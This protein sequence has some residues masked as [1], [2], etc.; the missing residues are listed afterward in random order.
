MSYQS[1]GHQEIDLPFWGKLYTVLSLDSALDFHDAI[2][3]PIK[4]AEALKNVVRKAILNNR[5]SYRGGYQDIG[6]AEHA[7]RGICE[8]FGEASLGSFISWSKSVF[9][10]NSTRHTKW[11]GWR[12]VFVYL[13]W[14]LFRLDYIVS[15]SSER[16]GAAY[17]EFQERSD[18]FFKLDQAMNVPM[19]EWDMEMYARHDM[20]FLDP[21]KFNPFTLI[22][23]TCT[24]YHFQLFWKTVQSIFLP[25]HEEELYR[26]GI[27]T[28][29][30]AD[31]TLSQPLCHPTN[32][33]C[34]VEYI[35]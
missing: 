18:I 8:V 24:L 29:Q 32:L 21:A 20:D 6:I 1:F 25:I 33:V 7:S 22:S 5:K 4:P 10:D 12:I 27:K 30:D 9:V 28:L 16:I 34:H 3:V 23:L 11:N 15:E 31:V 17:S 14:E 19:S 13:K 2:G 35:R 26:I